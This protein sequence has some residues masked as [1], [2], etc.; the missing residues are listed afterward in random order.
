MSIEI[1]ILSFVTKITSFEIATFL[2]TL[3]I[4][5]MNKKNKETKLC[6]QILVQMF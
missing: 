3:Y 4:C 1:F 2:N 6:Q 5:K